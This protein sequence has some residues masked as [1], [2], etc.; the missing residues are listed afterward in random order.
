M[1]FDALLH[2]SA[3]SSRTKWLMSYVF[4]RP[5]VNLRF[6]CAVNAFGAQPAQNGGFAGGGSFAFGQQQA[7]APPGF[8]AAQ[9]GPGAA[10]PF[11]ELQPPSDPP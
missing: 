7:A 4:F 2:R 5:M 11:G 1:N 9:P 8:G 6:A 3:V 10:A